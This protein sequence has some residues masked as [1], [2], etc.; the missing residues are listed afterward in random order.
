MFSPSSTLSGVF[1]SDFAFLASESLFLN[2]F[3]VAASDLA[4]VFF[5]EVFFDTRRRFFG[6]G[7]SFSSSTE[8]TS[9]SSAFF[10]LRLLLTS[11]V[12]SLVSNL[13]SS[14]AGFFS[15]IAFPPLRFL[16][17][18]LVF[19]LLSSVAGFVSS[20]AF[21]I[22][23]VTLLVVL[24]LASS[25]A[26][27]F[28]TGVLFVPFLALVDLVSRPVLE[29]EQ[30]SSTFLFSQSAVFF[31]FGVGFALALGFESSMSSSPRPSIGWIST[32]EFFLSSRLTDAGS[33][34]EDREAFVG[35][36]ASGLEMTVQVVKER[37]T[38][39][40]V[41]FSAAAALA[42]FS[43]CISER[44]SWRRSFSTDVNLRL[45]N[46]HR[47]LVLFSDFGISKSLSVT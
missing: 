41:S 9:S 33:G 8:S 40:S 34:T 20:I 16:P 42:K 5:C 46:E 15:S 3:F 30:F 43:L 24:A 6:R 23:R 32:A 36:T 39:A 17:T 12:T 37:A 47:I 44:F 31:R 10:L 19:N 1:S 27:V 14:V 26:C 11:L 18:S 25:R 22:L 28:S 2:S 45:H 4:L 29:M 38:A 7:L 35:T 13:P 21:P